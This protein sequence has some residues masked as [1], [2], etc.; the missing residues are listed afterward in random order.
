MMNSDIAIEAQGLT[1]YFGSKPVV[2]QLDLRIPRGAVTGLLGLNGA[3]KTTTLRMLLGLLE[4]TRGRSAVLGV[5]SQ[6]LSPEQ[7]ARIGYTPEGHFLYGWMTVRDS[8]KFQR[9]TFP[10]WNASMFAETVR[11]FA[12]DS[13][14][15]IGT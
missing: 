2:Q 3:G 14:Q 1:R 15:K 4:P 10:Q 12:I 5:D 13:A 11:R 7:R 8:E 9:D 6:T